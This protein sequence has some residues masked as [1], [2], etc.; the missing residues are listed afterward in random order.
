MID[1]SVTIATV[2]SAFVN[3]Y[4]RLKKPNNAIIGVYRVGWF[5]EF[6]ILAMSKDQ[7]G[8]RFVSVHNHGDFIVIL[9]LGNQATGIMTRYPTQS[10]FLNTEQISPGRI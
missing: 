5:L 8:Y 2:H 9:P 1:K 10:H 4:R 3:S 7:C 6:Y